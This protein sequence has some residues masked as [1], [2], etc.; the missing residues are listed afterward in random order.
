MAYP[1]VQKINEKYYMFYN[2]NDF[3]KHGFGYAELEITN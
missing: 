3:G 2:G 1:F